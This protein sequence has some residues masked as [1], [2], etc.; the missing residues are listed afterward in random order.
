MTTATSTLDTI[1]TP[2]RTAP[3]VR[4]AT[5]ASASTTDILGIPKPKRRAI[6]PLP[7]PPPPDHQRIAQVAYDIWLER[8]RPQGDDLAHWFA[9]ESIL[10][11]RH[12]AIHHRPIL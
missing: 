2:P 11:A 10:L 12:H 9:A 4:P 1:V 7:A 3:R 6:P 5:R 8:G